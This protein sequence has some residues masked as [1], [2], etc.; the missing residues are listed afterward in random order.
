MEVIDNNGYVKFNLVHLE[1]LI[2]YTWAI[3]NY[4]RVIYI[5]GCDTV[6]QIGGD[7]NSL[8][9]NGNINRLSSYVIMV[10]LIKK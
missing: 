6:S 9:I 10:M 2:T 8:I 3:K 4:I 5:T 7:S 1:Y